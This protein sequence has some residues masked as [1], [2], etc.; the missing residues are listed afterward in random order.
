[1]TITE[2]VVSGI[3]QGLTEFLPVSSSGH[4]VLVHSIFGLEEPKIFFDICLHAA[5]L[6][7]VVIY[8][9]GDIYELA[10]GRKFKWLIFLAIGTVPAVL[11]ALLFEERITAFF[12]SPVKVAYMLLVTAA[13]LFA[14]Q[15]SL[16]KRKA[17]GKEISYMTSMSVGVAQA[18]ALLPGIS[19]SGATVSAGLAGGVRAEEAFRFAF[20]LSVPAILGALAYKIIK[21]GPGVAAGSGF[22]S[23]A[24][25]AAAA[26]VTG[27][28]GLRLLWW[29]IKSRR[30]YIF[31]AYC[32]VLGLTVILFFK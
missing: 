27:L 8:F 15:L 4:L 20:L 32:L 31:S 14:G 12:T 18:F 23:Y 13:V 10:R 22:L 7:A 16:W 5:T 28:L 17:A 19:R 6:L 25:G 24:A 1:M 30:L 29:V 3:V 26:F 11:A 21:E 9:A 2:A